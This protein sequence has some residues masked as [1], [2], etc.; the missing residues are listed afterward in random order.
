M[1]KVESMEIPYLQH[2]TDNLYKESDVFA[3]C[4][5]CKQVSISQ[6]QHG[7]QQLCK[8]HFLSLQQTIHKKD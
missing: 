8:T 4:H 2:D 1:A 7:Y 5:K 6:H 3:I